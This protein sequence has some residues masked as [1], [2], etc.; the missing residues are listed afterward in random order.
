MLVSSYMSWYHAQF[1]MRFTTLTGS[2]FEDFVTAL[3]GDF[4]PGFINPRPVGRMGDYGCDG[5]TY[6]G[7][8]AYACFGYLPGRG[9]REL[10]AKIEGDFQRAKSKW[11]SFTQW[12]FVTNVGPGPEATQRL[13]QL[14]QAHAK[15]ALRPITLNLWQCK[16]LWNSCASKLTVEQLDPHFPGVPEAADVQLHA[17]V[18]LLQALGSDQPPPFDSGSEIRPVPESKMDFNRIPLATRIEFQVG[19]EHAPR[20][21]AW[22]SAQEDPTLRDRHAVRFREI[23]GQASA[24]GENVIERLYI[25]LAGQNFRLRSDRANAAYAVTAY[26][27]DECEIFEEPPAEWTG[28]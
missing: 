17:I 28:Q 22:Y 10:A 12:T 25:A 24:N 20:I 18:P 21:H 13:I 6:D 14:R 26:F 4:H 16:E 11:S 15:E 1:T 5:I 9:E 2:A 8:V 3:L 27:F 19:R 7:D 23:Y